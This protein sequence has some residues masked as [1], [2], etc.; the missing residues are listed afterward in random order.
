ME[1][2]RFARKTFLEQGETAGTSGQSAELL[3]SVGPGLKSC[4]VDLQLMLFSAA[5]T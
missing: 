5:N 2:G 4:C 3:E 1:F